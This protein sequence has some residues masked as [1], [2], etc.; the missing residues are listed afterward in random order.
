MRD[1]FD[2]WILPDSERETG[3]TIRHGKN[4]LGAAMTTDW[5][6]LVTRIIPV[7]QTKDGKPLLL[8]GTVYVDSPRIGDYPVIAAK[9]VEYDV[10][11]GQE[12]I[13]NASQARAKLT[14]LAQADFSDNG[15]DL[16]TVGLD[17]DFV[18]LGQTEAYAQ[19]ADLQ[20]VHLY[21]TCA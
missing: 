21:D 20:A 1:N 11:V 3:V 13:S 18:A 9:A 12:G 15:A 6:D 14:E 4:L 19:Y 17:V 5:S 16:P 2:I 8:S 7:G 10:K